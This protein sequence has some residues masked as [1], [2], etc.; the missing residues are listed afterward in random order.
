MVP[1]EGL[2]YGIDIRN[3]TG[4]GF[5]YGSINTPATNAQNF[6][7]LL[8]TQDFGTQ[9][10]RKRKCRAWYISIIPINIV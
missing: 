8:Q 4:T 9:R 5:D 7:Y 10:H 6:S 3:L 1:F 2:V